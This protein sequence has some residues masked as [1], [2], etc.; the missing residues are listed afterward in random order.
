MAASSDEKSMNAWVLAISSVNSKK[1][2][3]TIPSAPD[4]PRFKGATLR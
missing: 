2:H 1:V 3:T 4:P